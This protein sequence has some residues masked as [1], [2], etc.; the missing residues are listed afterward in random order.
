LLVIDGS[1]L[2]ES[3][4]GTP[5]FSFVALVG[6]LGGA[7][8]QVTKANREADA[9][10]DVGF[11]NF[12]FATSTNLLD[13]D[14]IWMVGDGCNAGAQIEGTKLPLVAAELNAIATF[15]EQGGGVFAVGDHYGLGSDMCGQ[16]P[17]VRAMRSWYDEGNP[18]KPSSLAAMPS[19]FPSVGTGRADTTVPNPV[20][21]YPAADPMGN[22][23]TTPYV[24]FQNQ[25]DALPQTI[26]P[27]TS[28]T[29]PILQTNGHDITVYPDHMHEG[30]ALG[31]VTGFDYTQPS[32][33]GD[34]SHDEFR[35]VA[36]NRQMPQ[37][38]A[39]GQTTKRASYQLAF[40]GSN[41]I[42]Y[43]AL[44]TSISDQ[45]P[46]NTLAVYDGFFAGVG[47][48]V[49]GSTFHHY[50]DI[51][52]I[53]ASSLSDPADS[54]VTAQL[55]SLVGGDAEPGQGLSSNAA[56]YAD[57]QAVYINITNW[58]ARPK[59]AI[60]LILERSTFS[61]DEVGAM[62]SFAAAIFVTVTGLT[63]SQFPNGGISTLSA[64][65]TQ[66]KHWAPAVSVSG[67]VPI[68][69]TPTAVASDDPTLADR[70]QT[71]TFTY[72]VVFTGNAFTFAGNAETV[73][74][75]AALTTTA[76][77][78]P[79]TDIAWIEL[80]KSANPFMLDLA[81]GNT[82]SW[83]SS[84][85]K[86][87]HV[88]A[89]NNYL[90]ATLPANATRADALTYLRSVVQ[91]MNTT[92]F[93]NLD[94]TEE[95]SVL[96][97][98]AVTTSNP[99]L[100]VYNFALARVRLS[101]AGGD[102]NPVQVFFR[103]FVT[104][105]TAALTYQLDGGGAPTGGYLQT[106]A[107]TPIDLPGTQ[108]GGTQWLSFPYFSATRVSPPSAQTDPDNSKLV[109]ASVG[110][111]FYGALI[112]NNLDD[113]YLTETPV[114]G[115]APVGLP[116]IV[117]GEHQCVV[118]EVIYS[119]AP[120]PSGANPATSD[121]ISQRNLAISP[122]ANPGLSA[123][124]IALHTFEIEA[125]PG[126]VS[127]D[128]PPDELLLAWSRPIPKGTYLALH[129]PSWKAQDVV[130]L[131]DRLYPRHEIR[132]I[133]AHTIEIPGGG[134]R[135]VPI[136][137]SLQR[138]AGALSVQLPLG[139]R[140]GQR[141]DLAVQ[142]I[143]NR[144]R[145]VEP[146]APRIE[147]ITLARARELL[148]QLSPDAAKRPAATHTARSVPRGVFDLGDGRSLVTDLSVFDSAGDHALIVTQPDPA[149]V[150][151]AKADSARWRE[152]I[153]TFQLG[154]PVSTKEDMLLNQL[155]LL[156]IMSWRL[157]HLNR[158]SPWYPT[159]VY[160]LELLIA[161]VLALGGD[162]YAVPPTP[163]GNIPQLRGGVRD[164]GHDHDHDHGHHGEHGRDGG[165]RDVVIVN[166]FPRGGDPKT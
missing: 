146:P 99:P 66:L 75:N 90:G 103:T 81:D 41:Q 160:Y 109:Q 18:N 154:I 48:I 105:T 141:F 62:P 149:L 148:K 12:N 117:M 130:D 125:T 16:I 26:T 51:N 118:T 163:G 39:T 85:I 65:S 165:K 137:R 49:T 76:V 83:L 54:T 58:L 34:T 25:S 69:I 136:P 139:I 144:Q 110:Y 47:R 135:Y 153:G 30:N 2:F 5:D 152:P 134:D 98:A 29:H 6:I 61:Q 72:T 13:F 113:P 101:S 155:Q 116:T 145:I 11:D 32:P 37:V 102:A 126:A 44:D 80:I 131:A 73:P 129:I 93:T 140:K 120:I 71:F 77:P 86:V 14:V 50:L 74:V 87:F 114:S 138:Q 106:S 119:G 1:F 55:N 57:V 42:I 59:P 27:T 123:S 133:D 31:V 151:A 4:V 88:V 7:G 104:Q 124:R 28:P 78:A 19:N 35:L 115:G 107:A 159:M 112:D 158:K 67:A 53:G 94:P 166:I 40:N 132:A 45:F 38:I 157:E 70:L 17:R 15:M 127:P 95:G 89:G 64:S 108:A 68:T 142:Q 3:N 9:T 52:L 121:K 24:Y 20:G 96:S 23:L 164:D 21:S 8:F 97:V 143:T 84:D 82:T 122:V 56:V 79:L 10:A 92:R 46:V 22:S 111:Q 91:N 60:S 162:P 100:N 36:G 33:F 43:E 63:P 150:A 128:L 147:K 161:K 156:S